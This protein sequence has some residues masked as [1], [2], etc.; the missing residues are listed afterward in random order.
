MAGT[1]RRKILP[2]R[3]API[4]EWAELLLRG[5]RPPD[6]ADGFLA[7]L[8]FGEATPGMP[9]ADSDEG[10]RLLARARYEPNAIKRRKAT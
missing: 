3:V 6:R 4:P 1:K 5:I 8:F 9:A 2:S 7:W 10:Q